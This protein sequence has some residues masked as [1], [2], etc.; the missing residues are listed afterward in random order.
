MEKLN[1]LTLVHVRKS[2]RMEMLL[3]KTFNTLI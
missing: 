2:V 1:W 3:F